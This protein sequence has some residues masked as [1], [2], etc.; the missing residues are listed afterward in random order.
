MRRG[1]AIGSALV[2]GFLLPGLDA[3][4]KHYQTGKITAVQ[5]K[6]RVL[7]YIFNAPMIEE[8][9]FYQVSVPCGDAIYI[10]EYRPRHSRDRSPDAVDADA[11]LPARVGKHYVCLKSA[12]DPGVGRGQGCACSFPARSPDQ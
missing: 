1:L 2:P 11:E 6:A 7:Y 4:G 10:G 5:K 12:G 3:A 8:D 9:R